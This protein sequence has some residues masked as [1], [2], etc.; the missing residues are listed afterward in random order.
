MDVPA[1]WPIEYRPPTTSDATARCIRY[2]KG[3]PGRL[4][5]AKL[6]SWQR[7]SFE[8]EHGPAAIASEQGLIAVAIVHQKASFPFIYNPD[9]QTLLFA[10]I[11]LTPSI[12][13]LDA[14]R[15]NGLGSSLSEVL[16]ST[17]RLHP[18]QLQ[19]DCHRHRAGGFLVTKTSEFSVDGGLRPTAEKAV[20]VIISQSNFQQKGSRKLP[21]Y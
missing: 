9:T 15:W 6:S 12:H 4:A 14:R 5:P 17:S 7:T 3:S 1:N 16:A 19:W 21:A 8:A 20:I 13:R 11:R 10:G 18:M 2:L